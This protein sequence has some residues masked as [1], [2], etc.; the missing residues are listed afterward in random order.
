FLISHHPEVGGK[1][2]RDGSEEPIMPIR[3]NQVHLS[4]PTGAYGLKEATSSVFVFLRTDP[5]CEHILVSL[6]VYAQRGQDD[7][8]VGL[9]AMTNRKMDAIQVLNT[10]VSKKRALSPRLK[11]L[12]QG[13]VE[14]ADGARLTILLTFT[15]ASSA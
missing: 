9:G 14:A 3:H 6:Q 13:L 2:S 4:S 12:S 11:L 1:K 15:C 5:Q 10:V 8:R 7:S